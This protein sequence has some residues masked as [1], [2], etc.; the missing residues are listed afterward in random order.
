MPKKNELERIKKKLNELDSRLNQLRDY[1][2]PRIRA[3]IHLLQDKGV[4][5]IEEMMEYIFRHKK[6]LKKFSEEI[7]FLLMIKQLR[8]KRKTG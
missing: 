8:R 1:S 7:Q 5:T 6:S 3:L 4:F 2:F